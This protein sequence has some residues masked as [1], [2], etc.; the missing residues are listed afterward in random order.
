MDL[1]EFPRQNL[2]ELLFVPNKALGCWPWV[3]KGPFAV[4]SHSTS[5]MLLS[6]HALDVYPFLTYLL[7]RFYP[8]SSLMFLAFPDAGIR[9]T[10]RFRDCVRARRRRKNLPPAFMCSVTWVVNIAALITVVIPP[11]SVIDFS[12]RPESPQARATTSTYH[13]HQ[14]QAHLTTSPHPAITS[15]QLNIDPAT[16][17][18]LM[19]I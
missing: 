6:C 17:P 15:H 9:V 10:R 5:P 3:P 8:S 12:Q 14:Q 18:L 1:L 13:R 4:T 19:P 2:L 11:V 7:S 16:H